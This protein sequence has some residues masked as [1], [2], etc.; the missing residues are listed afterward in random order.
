MSTVLTSSGELQAT[1][2]VEDGTIV[3]IV[4]GGGPG[5]REL[6]APG[7]IDLQVNGV[8]DVDCSDT[9]DD[10]W[11]RAG[12]LLAATGVTG[13]LPTLVSQPLER[14]GPQLAD[15]E[16]ARR[17]RGPG[18]T[19]LGAHLEGPFL[20]GQPGA[21]RP[22]AIVP[23]D[24]GWLA[25]LPET[26]RVV[27]LAPEQADANE[28]IEV[29]RDRG[30]VVS[31]GHSA[32]DH[33]TAVTAVDAGATMVT[34]L[35]NAMGPLHHRAPGLTGAALAD[36]RVV[37]GLI[38]DLVHVHPALL[39]TAFRTKGADRIALVTDGVGW[40]AGRLAALDIAL[41]DGAPRLADGTLAGSA[42]TMDQ[43]VRNVVDAAGVDPLDAIRSAS[44]T[45]A[46]LL[47][48]DTRGRITPGARADLVVLDRDDLSVRRTIVGGETV[49]E[50]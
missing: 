50:A 29:L 5:R 20:G 35:F 40:R 43:A 46:R 37:A 9:D 7:F 38:A 21:H 45:P 10:G 11:H 25:A 39:R 34:H 47:G 31:L 8:D 36:D 1:L 2:T 16:A 15:I 23:V 4:P 49:W 18:P 41:V 22:D 3:D 6:V 13:W 24:L 17:R 27:T 33:A 48:D 14:Y 12:E 19:V 32:A 26:V 42:L 28:A 44:T 30:I